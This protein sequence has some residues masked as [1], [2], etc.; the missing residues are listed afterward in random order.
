MNQFPPSPRVSQYELEEKKFIYKQTLL[1]KSVKKNNENF[2]DVRFFPFATGV[3]DT[4]GA[5]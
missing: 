1:P 2:S 3:N 5:S 4:G